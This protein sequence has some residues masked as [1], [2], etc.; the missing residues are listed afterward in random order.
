[1]AWYDTFKT[2]G[3]L[4]NKIQ[5]N[6]A[7]YATRY[8]VTGGLGVGNISSYG[9]RESSPYNP[10]TAPVATGV[11]DAPA[12]TTPAPFTAPAPAPFTAPGTTPGG[13]NIADFLN[14][15]NTQKSTLRNQ[16]EAGFK[17]ANESVGRQGLSVSGRASQGTADIN[18][19]MALA[20][21]QGA[22][23]T[24]DVRMGAEG[25]RY[26][27]GQNIK[28]NFAARGAIDSSY[29]Q[30]AMDAGLGD[31]NTQEKTNISNITQALDRARGEATKQKNSIEM[32]LNI[33]LQ[34]L[35]EKR[36]D[37]LASLQSQYDSGVISL[38]QMEYEANQP[39][40]KFA[41]TE[42]INK[43]QALSDTNYQVDSYL[44][45]IDNQAETA[46]GQITASSGAT[47]QAG[48]DMS[49]VNNLLGSLSKGL[50]AGYRKADFV[51]LLVSKGYSPEQAQSILD[52]AELWQP[53]AV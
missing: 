35:E 18:A 28:N 30:R 45:N 4:R 26:Q 5:S 32:E 9:P 22:K 3:D 34:D 11:M 36:Q 43:I 39:I 52:K 7:T 20:E 15:I 48:I 10:P 53:T 29:F 27:T 46:L 21:T 1:M 6:P 38:Q 17:R 19:S 49:N 23:N 8:A 16:Y 13:G 51:P 40:S 24:T 25:A 31:I 2:G 14:I 50:K 41:S 47:K 44:T 37:S 12:D 33:A 42:E